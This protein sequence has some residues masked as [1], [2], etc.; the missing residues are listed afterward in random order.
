MSVAASAPS[1]GDLLREWRQRR[2]VSQLELASR[3][4]VST[5]HLS[6]IETGRAR[7]SREM[8]LHLA[9]RLELP[10]RERNRVLLAGG[11]APVYPEHRLEDAE[12]GLVR[13]AVER[14]LAAHEPHPALV[15]DR[16]WTIVAS[17]RA[18]EMLTRGV[19]AELLEP[20]ANAL[21]IALHPDGM[22]PR[23]RNLHEWASHL[24]ERLRRECEATFD[25]ELD[26]LYAEL[27]TY[28]PPTSR[29]D[30]ESSSAALALLHTLQFD[31]V[32]LSFISTVT[33]FGTAL[34]VTVAELTIE[35]FY[36]A[37]QSTAA[38]LAAAAASRAN[39]D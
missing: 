17:N 7:P 23:I 35:A 26:A 31:D 38:A 36:P 32:E 6:F 16:H 4:A 25:P 14:F 34:D 13:D 9:Q 11:F 29:R 28:Y 10:L 22:A 33:R 12:M 8:I 5:R 21:R 15:I 27:A 18:V 30:Y 39:A 3:S 1:V 24:L 20:P 19:A 2:K 37:D